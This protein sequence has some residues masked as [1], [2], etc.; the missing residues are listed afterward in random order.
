MAGTDVERIIG[1]AV[2]DEQFRALLFAN[3]D[4]ALA[5]YDLSDQELE[6]VLSLLKGQFKDG[7]ESLG[8]E[9]TRGKFIF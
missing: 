9:V 8:G 7:L 5:G 2:L 1:R 3:P 4:A 6:L